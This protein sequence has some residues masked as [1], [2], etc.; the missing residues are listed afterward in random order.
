MNA[1]HR[2]GLVGVRRR[3]PGTAQLA[4]PPELAD[5]FRSW[6]RLAR[7][8]GDVDIAAEPDDMAKPSFACS[9]AQIIEELEQL[10]VTETAVREDRHG[11]SG[12]HELLQPHEAGVLEV[13]ALPGW[14][15]FP[16]GQ[17]QP[18]RR[19]AMPGHQIAC[20]RRLPVAIEAGPVHG[21]D[22]F[23][24]CPDQIRD[25]ACE[26]VPDIDALVGQHCGGDN[27]G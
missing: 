4:R 6:T 24:A 3:D 17:P 13:V 25:P 8:I 27:S 9:V 14:C 23:L 10:A 19:P 5:P 21:D 20:E 1:D 11:T 18:R 22:D 7:G 16:D 12:W 2:T 26:A 15:I